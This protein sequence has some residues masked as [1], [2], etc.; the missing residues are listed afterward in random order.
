MNVKEEP[1]VVARVGKTLK[2]GWLDEITV[3]TSPN[4]VAMHPH[5]HADD[6]LIFCLRGRLAYD[7]GRGKSVVLAAGTALF[8]P[9][10]TKHVLSGGVNTPGTRMGFHL[11]KNLT[12]TAAFRVFTAADYRIVRERFGAAALKPFR[13]DAAAF[14]AVRELSDL[15]KASSALPSERAL[16]RICA[17]NVLLRLG[18]VLSRPLVNPLPKMMDEAV[19]YLHEHLAEPVGVNDL[20]LRM[21]YGRS[22]LF[23]LFK[24]HTGLSPNDYLVRLRIQKAE[25]L[26]KTGEGSVAEVARAC[27]F[28]DPT[29]FAAVFRKYTGRTPTVSRLS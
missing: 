17:C 24:A 12:P 26:L 1:E 22:R 14:A 16:L 21:G 5:R 29:Y 9:A 8:I 25:G 15:V 6:E 13:L 10:G 23:E 18:R 19:A 7:F 20:V 3:W 4:A 27:G 2:L 28:A 11:R